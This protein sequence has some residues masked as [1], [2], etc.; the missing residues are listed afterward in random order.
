MTILV[1]GASGNAG[2]AV[3]RSLLERAAPVR[4]LVRSAQTPV[5]DGAIRVV[6]D[7]N[8][9]ASLRAGLDGATGLFL[10]AGYDRVDELLTA[11]SAAGVGQVVLLSS[12]S[13]VGTDTDNAIAAYHLATEVAVRRSGLPWTFI[14]P[15]YFMSNTYRWLD[16]LR[17][18]DVVRAQFPDLPI[19]VLDPRDLGDV[20]ATAFLGDGHAGAA[21]RLTGPRALTPAERVDIL[22]GALGRTLRCQGLSLAE[23]RDELFASMPE[24]Y[25]QAML[26]FYADG[27]IDETSVTSAVADVTGHPPRTFEQWATDHAGTLR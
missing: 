26:A 9:P 24:K 23:T 18:G 5:P 16:Q 14:R 27:V 6:G 22:G 17:A 8:D 21:Y 1:A 12:S 25:A 11:A 13:V 19:S 10:L 7:L 15:N 3:V 20:V 2:G 4:A